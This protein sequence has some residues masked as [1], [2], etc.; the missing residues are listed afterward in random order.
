MSFGVSLN[1]Q[2]FGICILKYELSKYLWWRLIWFWCCSRDIVLAL[3]EL[4]KIQCQRVWI[5]C[6][7][8]ACFVIAFITFLFLFSCFCLFCLCYIAIMH[9]NPLLHLLIFLFF[10]LFHISC[11][12][13]SESCSIVICNFYKGKHFN[14]LILTIRS[15]NV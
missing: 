4:M 9:S 6:F 11:L 7:I 15:V 8:L 13:F 10:L 12:L 1:S 5:K 14:S 3:F 2:Q